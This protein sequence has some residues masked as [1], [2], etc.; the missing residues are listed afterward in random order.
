VSLSASRE[1]GR[2]V[3]EIVG[4]SVSPRQS[5]TVLREG[6]ASLW[7]HK[8]LAVE[9]IR[10][11]LIGQ[12]ANQALG[13]FWVIVHPVALLLIYIFVFV[14]VLKVKIHRDATMVRDYTDYILAGLVP[15]LAIAQTLG[16]SS[17]ALIS[18]SNL[19]KQVIFPIEVLPPASVVV[20]MTP[21]AISIPAIVVYQ[22]ISGQGVPMTILLTPFF[23]M[24]LLL[25]LTGVAFLL[26]AVTPFFRDLKDFITIFL[27][28]GVYV[29]PAFYLPS[30][31][32]RAFQP[33]ILANPFSYP[34]FVC[35]D[36]FYYGQIAHPWAWVVF[37]LLSIVSYV[38]G[39]RVFRRIRPFIATVL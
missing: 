6:L 5:T 36:I 17:S 10:R 20:S 9:M 38:L 29:I 8:A 34:I 26:A 1:A 16:R 22:L 4:Q 28:A 3:A 23:M 19:V 32:P 11:E 33:I 39:Y 21:M 18:Q 27:T 12:Y 31:I 35:Q 15:W 7:R 14:L 25:F 13:S 24:T 37:V 30:W 2:R